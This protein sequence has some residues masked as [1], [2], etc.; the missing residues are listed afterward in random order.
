MKK[1]VNLV[2]KS[3]EENP[4]VNMMM[5]ANLIVSAVVAFCTLV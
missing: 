1:L 4:L 2:K 5:I 3:Y